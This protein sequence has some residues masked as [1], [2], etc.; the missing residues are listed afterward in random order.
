METPFSS[1]NC[2]HPCWVS[3]GPKGAAGAS[4]CMCTH[5]HALWPKNTHT[6]LRVHTC[7]YTSSNF[8][9]HHLYNQQPGRPSK[10]ISGGDRGRMMDK[11]ACLGPGAESI[12]TIHPCRVSEATA[13]TD[14]KVAHRKMKKKKKTAREKGPSLNKSQTRLGLSG[15]RHSSSPTWS[16]QQKKRRRKK[17]KKHFCKSC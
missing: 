9:E 13:I 6:H 12:P 14:A 1:L 5:A 2:L 11:Q 8:W 7:A 15:K 4:G 16:S 17:G 3:I 10:A